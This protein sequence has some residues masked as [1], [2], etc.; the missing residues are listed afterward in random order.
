[1]CQNS[2]TIPW[3]YFNFH[4]DHSNQIYYNTIVSN[5]IYQSILL[6]KQFIPVFVTFIFLNNSHIYILFLPHSTTTLLMI[7]V[8]SES[9]KFHNMSNNPFSVAF[10]EVMYWYIIPVQYIPLPLDG[11]HQILLFNWLEYKTIHTTWS[12]QNPSSF[13]LNA[14]WIGD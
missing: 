12:I 9:N 13:I 6:S 10:F 1:M 11:E 14:I 7:L 4:F 5:N 8:D 2:Q 3:E